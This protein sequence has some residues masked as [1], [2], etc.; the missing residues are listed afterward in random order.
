MNFEVVGIRAA[1]K[2]C[3]LPVYGYFI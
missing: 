3:L 2:F 1:S